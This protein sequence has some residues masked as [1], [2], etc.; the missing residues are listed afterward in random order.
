M[1][2]KLIDSYLTSRCEFQLTCGHQPD[3]VLL[4]LLEG[5]FSCT[6]GENEFV[7]KAGDIAIFD[8]ETAMSRHV[9][10]PIRFLYVKFQLRQTEFFSVRSGVWHG[11]DDRARQDLEKILS[12]SSEQTQMGLHLREH[13]LN[14]LFLCLAEQPTTQEPILIPTENYTPIAYMKK[15]IKKGLTLEEL[16]RACNISVSSMENRFRSLYG[17]SPY[18]YF[19]KLRMEEA[20]RLLAKTSYTVTEIAMRCGYENLFYFCNAFKKHCKMT[21]TEDRKLHLM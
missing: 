21:P 12:L 15:Q 9:L 3:N 16:A 6:I 8:T 13:Y 18:R 1:I 2:V 17:M 7:V 10:E 19:I 4:Y 11:I 14:D 20:E 5:S